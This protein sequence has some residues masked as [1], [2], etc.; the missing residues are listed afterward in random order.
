MVFSRDAQLINQSTLRHSRSTLKL[1]E[2]FWTSPELFCTY[3]NKSVFCVQLGGQ[4]R[5]KK[6]LSSLCKNLR[7]E[8][9]AQVF[10]GR[11]RGHDI[12]HSHELP[13][14]DGAILVLIIEVKEPFFDLLIVLGR[15]TVAHHLPKAFAC[16]APLGILSDE[17]V[18]VKA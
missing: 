2:K 3:L 17:V 10:L 1:F 7:S 9:L 12:H 13:E 11:P 5:A 15:I 18:K 14:A 6:D 8:N 4:G 16:D